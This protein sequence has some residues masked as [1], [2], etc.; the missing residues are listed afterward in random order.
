MKPELIQVLLAA[1]CSL[2]AALILFPLFIKISAPLGLVDKPDYRKIHRKPV[3]AVG[4]L[5]IASVLVV[6][7][8]CSSALRSF[9]MSQAA[10]VT[11]MFVLAV[12]G[13]VDDR[14]NLP[15]MLRLLIQVGCAV[16][17]AATGIRLESLHG[18]LG[19]QQLPPVASWLMTIF[20][21]TGVTNAFNL[22][23]GID[24]LAGS[25]SLA[26][27]VLLSVMSL[28]MHRL[29]WLLLLLPLIAAL[30]VFLQYNWRPAKVFMGDSGSL[31]FGFFIAT[32]GV[33]FIKEAQS[34]NIATCKLFTVVVTGYCMIPVMDALRVFYGRIKNGVSPFQADRT[35]LHHLLLKH[36]LLHSR[37]TTKLLF[38][39]LGMVLLSALASRFISV[40]WI[41]VAQ[42]IWVLFFVW[43]VN[44]MSCFQRWYRFIKKRELAV[45]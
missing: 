3:P 27:M 29:N 31:L 19:I 17:M 8:L 37:A 6:A 22:I 40:Q 44:T 25:L 10:M 24:G 41:I 15:A 35:H 2:I 13:M 5:V 12:T 1:G 26:N 11:S 14:C 21:I 9:M 28:V 20:I 23:D 39:H 38:M 43:V 30:L 7:A 36:H 32:M 16:A 42:A 4:G 33:H 18:L 34:V 45:G